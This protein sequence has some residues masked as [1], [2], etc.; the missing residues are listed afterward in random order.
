MSECLVT[1]LTQKD[2]TERRTVFKVMINSALNVFLS[3]L[4]LTFICLL[5]L[6][7]DWYSLSRN[8]HKCLCSLFNVNNHNGY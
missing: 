5:P 4:E 3:T 2:T 7:I 8:Y 1:L 6:H